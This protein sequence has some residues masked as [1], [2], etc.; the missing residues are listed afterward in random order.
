MD[1]VQKE[2]REVER[3]GRMRRDGKREERRE[4]GGQKR[5]GRE[6]K[7]GDTGR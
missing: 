3:G 5:R 6:G 1:C 2:R 4:G 7:E